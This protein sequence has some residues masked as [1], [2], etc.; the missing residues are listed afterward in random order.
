MHQGAAPMAAFL[1]TGPDQQPTFPACAPPQAALTL[2]SM[3]N[4]Q[5]I[6]IWWWAR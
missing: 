1:L 4:T 6:S 3:T 5:N 2:A